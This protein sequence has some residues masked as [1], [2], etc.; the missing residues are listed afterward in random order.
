MTDY[1]VQQVDLR[2]YA[3]KVLKKLGMKSE[4]IKIIS[5][6]LIDADLRGLNS[7]GVARLPMVY[8]E[9]IKKGLISK[10]SEYKLI[11]KTGAMAIIDADNGPG[12]VAAFKAIKHAIKI[13]KKTGISFV[14]IKNSNHFGI[15][16]YFSMEAARADM[17][18][19]A[20]SNA[21]A[22][23]AP[24]G[25]IESYIGTN[26]FSIAFPAEKNYPIVLDMATSV[27]AR[28]KILLKAKEGENIPPGLA[29]DKNGNPTTDPNQIATLLAFGGAKGSGIGIAIDI[30][31]GILMDSPFGI[32]INRADRF[33][34]NEQLSQSVGALNISFFTDVK[35]FKKNIDKM[36]TE[37]KKLRHMGGVKEIF[38]PGEIEMKIKEERSKKGIPIS[39]DMFNELQGLEGCYIK[40]Y[41]KN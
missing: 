9:R 3:E 35:N 13:A 2:E 40:N 21:G 25:A 6:S 17:I 31:T 30:L 34:C 16:S 29:L 32:H 36:I 4:E 8:V 11:K 12:Q 38:L 19:F 23:V 37:I 7:H 33:N 26:P 1:I 14:S 5:D 41:K 39:E 20:L 15:A 27:V 18:G 22:D 10:N 24:F 28:G